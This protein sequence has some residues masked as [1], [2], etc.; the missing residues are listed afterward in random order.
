MIPTIHMIPFK[1]ILF[2]A[3]V[4]TAA[5][6]LAQQPRIVVQHAGSVQVFSDLGEA[7]T[8]AQNN[9]ELYLSGGSFVLPGGLA[10]SKTLHFIGAG[11]HTDSTAASGPTILSTG[12]SAN[13]RLNSSASGSSFSYIT[14]N[15]PGNGICFGL[16]TSELDQTVESVEFHRCVFWQTVSLGVVAPCGSTSSFT[17]CIFHS[18][19]YGCNAT[20][21]V[22]RCIFDYQAGTGAEISAFQGGGLTMLNCVCLGTR[23][24]DSGASVVMNSVFTRTSA[25][26]W[27]S[28]GMTMTNNLLVSPDLT[29]NMGSF[30]ESG[31]ILGVPEGTIFMGES[32][33]DYQFS[34]N[35]HLQSTCPGVGAGTDGTDMGIYGTD[36]PYK[37]GAMPHTPY[38][39]KVN[40]A[41]GTDA[42]GS[43]PVS[44][45][46]AAQ[47]N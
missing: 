47:P 6:A 10:L 39:R 3:V 26:F 4:A 2:G 36:S 5:P 18:T 17:E 21:Q 35:L 20:T 15:V 41:P 8:A 44:V 28:S 42:N 30:T 23:I 13:F 14:F 43:L 38:F 25:P 27:Q 12:T 11:V 32:D 40:I 34:D 1:H 7:I 22:T 31:N 19:L 29:S 45:R 24:G 16:G 9:A 33:T 46:V 37:D